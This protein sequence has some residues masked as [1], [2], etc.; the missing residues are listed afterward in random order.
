MQFIFQSTARHGPATRGQCTRRPDLGCMDSWSPDSRPKWSSSVNNATSRMSSGTKITPATPGFF[1]RRCQNGCDSPWDI[2][3]TRMFPAMACLE[4]SGRYK[5]RSHCPG[6]LAFSS[7]QCLNPSIHLVMTSSG[8]QRTPR[9]LILCF[10]G[11][12]NEYDGD[13]SNTQPCSRMS[14]FLAWI[15]HECCQTFRSF[16]KG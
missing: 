5:Y 15:E 2:H 13:V 4:D 1:T 6:F 8:E 14:W 11:T 12:S 10:D 3:T 7:L 9:T 16:E